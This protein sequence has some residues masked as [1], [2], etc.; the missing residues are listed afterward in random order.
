MTRLLLL[1]GLGALTLSGIAMTGR[2]PGD[3]A[4][5]HY[6]NPRLNPDERAD[7]L[8][9]RMSP[10]EKAAMLGGSG[11]ME[12]QPNERLGIPAIKMAD[13]P[14]GVRN[15]I[16]SS[17]LTSAG[18]APPFYATAFPAGIA[19]AAS[20]DVELVR[21]EGRAIA[22]EAKAL[23]RD[24]ILGPTVN[25]ARTPLWGRNFEGYGEIGRASCRER[26][27]RTV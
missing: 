23:G 11:W 8:L 3:T 1:V 15:W 26:V 25:I 21:A 7:D 17:A 10:G 5:P 6:K 4:P 12:S 14:M 19:M 27:F 18:A 2:A 13:G 16:G 24:M 20:W 9:G 22:Q